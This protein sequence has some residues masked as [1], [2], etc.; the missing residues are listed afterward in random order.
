MT[1]DSTNVILSEAANLWSFCGPA[2]ARK[3]EMF[4]S[5]QHDS[6]HGTDPRE[7]PPAFVPQSR[8]YSTA[9]RTPSQNDQATS[10]DVRCGIES[11]A[12]ARFDVT[13][14]PPVYVARLR[15]LRSRC[16]VTLSRRATCITNKDIHRDIRVA[17]R[18]GPARFQFPDTRRFCLRN[19]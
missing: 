11:L 5:A 2:A 7:I 17:V 1:S 19:S 4:R 9:K 14:C 16:S 6:R 13:D 18:T 10:R 12:P 15:R 3:T 8:N